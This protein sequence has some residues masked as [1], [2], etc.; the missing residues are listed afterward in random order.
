VQQLQRPHD[1]LV[2][3]E[4]LQR[5]VDLHRQHLRDVLAAV[6]DATASRCCSGGR[7]RVSQVTQ[8]SA[9]KCISTCSW[10]LPSHCA[11]RPSA[12]WNEKRPGVKPFCLANGVAANSSRI[13]R[14]GTG[15]GRRVA[16][17]RAADRA[18]VDDDE[19]ERRFSPSRQCFAAVPSRSAGTS[20]SMTSDD[21]PEPDTPVTAVKQPS[22]TSTSTPCRLCTCT[23]RSAT[24]P[25]RLRRIA[26]IGIG[27]SPRSQLPVRQ[28]PWR[29]FG[30]RAAATMRPPREPA[31]GP[32]SSTSRRR[33]PSPRRVR[34][35]ARCCRGR[36]VRA[37]CAAGAR[38]RAGAGRRSVRRARRARRPACCRAAWR[39]GCAALRRPTASRPSDRASG[40]RAR[41]RAGTTGGCRVPSAR[42]RRCAA[43]SRSS[44]SASSS[45]AN[46]SSTVFASS[47]GKRA[48]HRRAPRAAPAA[49]VRRGS[50]A[51]LRTHHGSEAL[52][53][54]VLAV[55]AVEPLLDLA[56]EA[57]PRHLHAPLAPACRPR[58]S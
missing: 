29:D 39:A 30:R 54:R 17:R 7:G 40:S 38:C 31:P 45:A 28:S 8:T 5:L 13:V 32:M 43:R 35:R 56:R 15:V 51:R 57:L 34:P 37:A 48:R 33:A 19:L 18:L 22:G 49:A 11:Q 55:L 47:S 26:G 20:A 44:F 2:V 23:P 21:L 10:P 14:E 53:A 27:S 24:W 52:V 46:A 36:A 58:P 4:E 16:R 9:R 41:S 12:T 50:R 1:V 42:R 6:L 25:E 3:A